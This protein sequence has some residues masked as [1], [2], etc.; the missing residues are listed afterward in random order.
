M[1]TGP[2]PTCQSH[3]AYGHNQ[4]QYLHSMSSCGD[5][6]QCSSV[7]PKS[8]TQNDIHSCS[9]SSSFSWGAPSSPPFHSTCLGHKKWLATSLS[10][11]MQIFA[12]QPCPVTWHLQMAVGRKYASCGDA[13]TLLDVITQ[14]CPGQTTCPSTIPAIFNPRVL[15]SQTGA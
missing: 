5:M 12:L 2:W 3:A 6:S 14:D 15:Q 7:W 13:G 9:L 1:H 8:Q 11:S 4:L 10:P